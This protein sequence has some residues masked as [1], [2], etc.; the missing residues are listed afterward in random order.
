MQN[1]QS[2]S[3]A[4]YRSVERLMAEPVKLSRNA[5][6]ANRLGHSGKQYNTQQSNP[7]TSVIYM[8]D[9]KKFSDM[10]KFIKKLGDERLSCK[11]EFKINSIEL[12]QEYTSQSKGPFQIQLV[13][14]PLKSETKV[15][16]FESSKDK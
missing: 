2:R 5:H 14:G 10:A 6:S 9:Q 16:S 12:R 3:R 13:R 4:A 11:V 7:G 1:Y 15:F 8:R